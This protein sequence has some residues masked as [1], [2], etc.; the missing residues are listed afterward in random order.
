ME[1]TKG[2]AHCLLEA[3]RIIQKRSVDPRRTIEQRMP[4]ISV[5][6]MLWYAYDENWE[7]LMQYDDV[8]LDCAQCQRSM[9]LTTDDV[10][11]CNICENCEYFEPMKEW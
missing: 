6:D 8:E 9:S 5:R 10:A 11:F 2:Q 3:I 1:L 7:C 4:Y